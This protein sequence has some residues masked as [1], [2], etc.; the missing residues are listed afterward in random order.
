MSAG[1]KC[2]HCPVAGGARCRSDLFPSFCRCAAGG[3]ATQLRH[4]VNRSGTAEDRPPAS[5]PSSSPPLA[6]QAANLAG[7][8]ARF[9]ASGLKTVTPEERERRLQICRDCPHFR[10]GKCSLCGCIA[11][12]KARLASE[13]CPDTPPR[14]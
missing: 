14:W 12:W 2:I 4:I 11:R 13:S 7:A 6:E 8:A 1:A 3:D 9:V 10:G 5:A